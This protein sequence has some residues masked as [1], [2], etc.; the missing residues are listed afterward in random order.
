[1]FNNANVT[2]FN[3]IPLQWTAATHRSRCPSPNRTA[4]SIANSSDSTS[5]SCAC[6]HLTSRRPSP[7]Y[8]AMASSNWSNSSPTTSH[9]HISICRL[10]RC[11]RV[12]SWSW[13]KVTARSIL[14]R[15]CA[16]RGRARASRPARMGGCMR[17][18]LLGIRRMVKGLKYIPMGIYILASFWTARSMGKAG[19]TGST[20]PPKTPK[21]MISQST[22]KDSG[23]EGYPMAKG[24][25]RK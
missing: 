5:K 25:I 10:R 14:V 8:S 16:S 18:I 17:E 20:S 4:V 21:T 24:F 19:S 3:F 6:T 11:C 22:M 13:S 15:L 7:V 2:F 1:M 9:R 23:G 12:N